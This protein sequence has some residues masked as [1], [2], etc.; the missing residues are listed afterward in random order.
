MKKPQKQKAKPEKAEDE[1]FEHGI[2]VINQFQLIKLLPPNKSGEIDSTIKLIKDKI[3]FYNNPTEEE[4][5]AFREK[6]LKEWE[7]RNAPRERKQGNFKEKREEE[8]EE[9]PQPRKE[10]K[11]YNNKK[12]K[13]A[14]ITEGDFPELA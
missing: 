5:A 3:D 4:K 9:A 8:G 6:S 12:G 10:K 14:E 11:E 7:E 1:N 2:E 13:K